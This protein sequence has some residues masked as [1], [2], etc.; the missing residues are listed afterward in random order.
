MKHT[1][2]VEIIHALPYGSQLFKCGS[3]PLMIPEMLSTLPFRVPIR[4]LVALAIPRALSLTFRG[5][6]IGYP[7]ISRPWLIAAARPILVVLLPSFTAE[8]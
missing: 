8:M 6:V 3:E 1:H 2:R 5:F 7:S 4:G